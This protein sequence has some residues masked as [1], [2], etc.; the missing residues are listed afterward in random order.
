MSLTYVPM[1]S[2]LF[3]S[4]KTFHKENFSDRII[5]VLKRWY[6]PVLDFSLRW[7]KIVILSMVALFVFSLSVFNRLG[8]EF[9]PTLEEGDLT[10]E[11]SM[12]QGTSLTQVIETFGMAEKILKDKF[13]EVK[14][15]VTRI[16]SAEIPTDP[17]PIERGDMMLSMKPKEDWTTANSREEMMEAMEEALEAIPG[18]RVELTQPMQ[19]RFNELITGIRQDVAIKIYGEDLE[20]LTS[21]AGKLAGLIKNVK[22]VSEPFVEKVTGLPQIQVQYNRDRIAVYGLSISDVNTVLRTA[23]AGNVAGVVFEGDKRFDMVVR[24][25]SDLRNDLSNLENLFVTLPSGNHIP[26]NQLAEISYKTAPAQISHEDGQRRIY[27]GFNV[28]GRDVESTV[29]EI[30][31]I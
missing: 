27:V 8:G 28:R 4:R 13:P 31:K 11:I 17:M 3:L 25:K 9:I 23:F 24:L 18:I 26:L 5:N 6:R 1:M 12:V 2:A 16:G 10:V 15:A 20:V 30:H 14:Q 21:H 22:G 7:K 19:M 29:E